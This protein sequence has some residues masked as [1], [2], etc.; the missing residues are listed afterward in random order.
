LVSEPEG[1]EF[2]KHVLLMLAGGHSE[3]YTVL[4]LTCNIQ[5]HNSSITIAKKNENKNTC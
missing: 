1:S 5:L 4:K 2:S 3:K